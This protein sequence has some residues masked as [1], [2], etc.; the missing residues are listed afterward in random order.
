MSFPSARRGAADV[1]LWLSIVGMAISVGGQA[2]QMLVV[3]PVWTASPPESIRAFSG[4]PF[5]ASLT[6]FH[7]NP[8][9]LVGA[10]GGLLGALILNWKV[11]TLRNWILPA[12]GIEALVI[13]GTYF[14]VYPINDVLFVHFGGGLDSIAIKTMTQQ[15]LV[16]DRIRFILKLTVFLCLL[17]A[18]SLPGGSTAKGAPAQL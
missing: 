13:L 4:T 7:Q 1:C 11:P 8:F 2:F 16:A 5:P 14:Y 10:V 6:R 3:D 17:R 15:W 18:L 12:V 9:I